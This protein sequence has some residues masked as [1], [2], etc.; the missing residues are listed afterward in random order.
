MRRE[1]LAWPVGLGV[2]SGLLT[3]F[4][5]YD[6]LFHRTGIEFILGDQLDRHRQV[7][8][9]VAIDPWQY[10][11]LPKLVVEAAIRAVQNQ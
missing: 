4:T 10:R 1:S 3:F 6:Q 5:V 2:V 7:L 11:L 9:G 8:A